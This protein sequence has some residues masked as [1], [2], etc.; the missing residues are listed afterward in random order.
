M[1]ISPG[2]EAA[3]GQLNAAFKRLTVPSAIQPDGSLPSPPAP[4]TPMGVPL[5]WWDMMRY[6]WRGTG[7]RLWGGRMGWVGLDGCWGVE[8]WRWFCLLQAPAAL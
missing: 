4:G 5:P 8:E 7:E 1:P 3:F 2:L 6:M